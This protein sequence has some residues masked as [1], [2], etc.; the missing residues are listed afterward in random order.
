M[1][2]VCLALQLPLI[3]IEV[4][5]VTGA[6]LPPAAEAEMHDSEV[7]PILT[8]AGEDCGPPGAAVKCPD[9]NG[10]HEFPARG[11]AGLLG[12]AFIDRPLLSTT[13]QPGYIWSYS[14]EIL[15]I[16]RY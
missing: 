16:S 1:I 7:S 10:G 12:A 5:C 9:P 14:S 13:T 3:R 6:P 8:E 2:T 11:F 4:R 15:L